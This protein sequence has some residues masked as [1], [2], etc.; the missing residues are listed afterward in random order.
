[1]KTILLFISVSRLFKQVKPRECKNTDTCLTQLLIRN[2]TRSYRIGSL[3]LC[4]KFKGLVSGSP[5]LFD[6]HPFPLA[7]SLTLQG[8]FAMV[9]LE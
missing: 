3:P 2:P 5:S 6:T 8:A 1:M 4:V 9:T 7:W